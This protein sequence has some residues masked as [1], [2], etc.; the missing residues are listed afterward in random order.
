MNALLREREITTAG[1]AEILQRCESEARAVLNRL[2]DRGVLQAR[3]QTRGRSYHLS[4]GAYR[5]LGQG[6]GYV[7]ARGFEPVQQEQMVLA[8]VEAHGRITRREAAELCQI[9]P[10][11]ATALLKKLASRGELILRGARRGAHYERP[12]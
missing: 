1:A 7:R 5:A 10:R 8:H 9:T 2:V 3:G 11:Q 12:P 6:A 4:A